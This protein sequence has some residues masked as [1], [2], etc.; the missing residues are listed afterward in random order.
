MF[1]GKRCKYLFEIF[2][3]KDITDDLCNGERKVW[4]ADRDFDTITVEQVRKIA[5]RRDLYNEE[6]QNCSDT[7]G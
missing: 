1:S 5:D 4:N 2:M 6:I 3:E 7:D